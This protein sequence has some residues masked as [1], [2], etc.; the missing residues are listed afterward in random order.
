VNTKTKSDAVKKG[1]GTL[2]NKSKALPSKQE[3]PKPAEAVPAPKRPI[4]SYIVP[5]HNVDKGD[6]FDNLA[7]VDAQCGLDPTD[8]EVLVIDDASDPEYVLP[9]EFFEQFP[10]LNITI[11]ACKN[12]G[13]PGV[14]RQV[15]IDYANAP[16]VMF[17]DADDS[18]FS[19]TVLTEFIREIKKAAAANKPLD[20]INS[21]WYE[22]T[23]GKTPYAE[24]FALHENDGTWMHGKVFSKIFLQKEGLR[25]SNLRVHEDLFFNRVALPLTGESA[26][27]GTK[28]Y[29]WKYRA[30]SITRKNGAAYSHNSLA[31]SVVAADMAYSTLITQHKDKYDPMTFDDNKLKAE[32]KFNIAAGVVGTIYYTYFTVQAWAASLTAAELKPIEDALADFFVKYKKIYDTYPQ[33]Y[34]VSSY[35]NERNLVLK[36]MPGFIESEAVDTFLWRIVACRKADLERMAQEAKIKSKAPS[37]PVDAQK[38]KK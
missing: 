12:N 19:C 7:L 23:G 6:L 36:Q 35:S 32:H 22:E 28:S 30:N 29:I 8:V 14:A 11:V 5:C 24:S 9:K 16:Y 4:L 25:F 38:D 33:Q 21:D 17:A 15:G 37:E 10:H 13:G 1:T 26:K 2:D 3:S 18:L 20:F 34:K 31:V 27:I